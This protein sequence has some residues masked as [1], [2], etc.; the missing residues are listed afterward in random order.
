[1]QQIITIIGGHG[2]MGKLFSSYWHDLGY[3]VRSLGTDDWSNASSLLGDCDLAIIS[4]PIHLT[5]DIIYQVSSFL[6]PT[7]II[8]D[9]TSIKV[10]PLEDM[11]NAHP[12]PVLALHPMFGPTI[13][14][15]HN[16]VIINCG[17]RDINT[18]QWVIESLEQLGFTIR[19]MPAATHDQAMS[20]IQGI[21]HFSTFILGSFLHQ[22]QQHPEDLFNLASP[23]YQAKLALMGRI[24]DQDA[25]LYADIITADS[26]RL[27]L[28]EDYAKYLLCWVGKLKNQNTNEFITEF[29]QTSTWMGNFTH[30]A[31][32]ASDKFL[33]A[34]TD[35]FPN[36]QNNKG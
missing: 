22:H 1:M 27:N 8:A 4:V 32:L 19:S 5:T 26:A 6:P 15:P 21:E 11:L 31:Q 16:Q 14:T 30:D 18:S 36:L 35:S 28:I 23:I 20:F 2:M 33:T 9:F 7:A 17:G 25:A 3:T 12:G 24:F 29:K 13:P 10:K 34:V